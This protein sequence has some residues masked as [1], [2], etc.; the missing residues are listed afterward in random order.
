MGDENSDVRRE[1]IDALTRL[2][3]KDV[4]AD[5]AVFISDENDDVRRFAADAMGKLGYKD[6]AAALHRAQ[7]GGTPSSSSLHP[8]RFLRL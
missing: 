2:G 5:I 7:E 3:A 4:A 6:S 1:A 8:T